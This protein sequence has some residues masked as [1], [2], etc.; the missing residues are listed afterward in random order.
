MVGNFVHGGEV[1]RDPGGE[2]ELAN[3]GSQGGGGGRGGIE[4]GGPVVGEAVG[5]QGRL[6]CVVGAQGVQ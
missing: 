1:V 6:G 4:V 3:G 5:E 2:V